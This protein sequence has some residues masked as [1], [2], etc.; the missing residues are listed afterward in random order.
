MSFDGKDGEPAF[1][2]YK[3]K[4]YDMNSLK[5]WTNGAH[6]KHQAGHDLTDALAKAPHGEEKLISLKVVG[7][8]NASLKPPKTFAQKA[9]YFIAYMNLTIVFIVLFVIAYWRWGL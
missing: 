1:V 8:Y 3:G 9:F 6:M 4:V 7:S 5:L 2:A